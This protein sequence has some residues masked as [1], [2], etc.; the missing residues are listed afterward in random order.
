MKKLIL[1]AT[2]VFVILFAVELFACPYHGKH[3]DD[4]NM[5]NEWKDRRGKDWQ[6][7]NR[8]MS[9]VRHKYVMRNGVPKK[10]SRLKVNLSPT[11]E[12]I[13]QGKK[14]YE[15]NCLTCHGAS[16]RGDGPAGQN[17]TPSP[18]DLTRSTKMRMATDSYLFWT[19]SEGGAPV[20]TAMP[21]FKSSLKQEEI[22]K[23]ILYIRQL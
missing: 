10:Y 12:I 17:L 22:S 1:F 6:G 3:Q 20:N 18:I 8:H 19:I 21:G 23:I 15:A 4:C 7:W 5:Y 11:S 16:G 9:M 14:L 13:G 2:C